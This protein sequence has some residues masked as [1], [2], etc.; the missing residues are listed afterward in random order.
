VGVEGTKGYADEAG[1]LAPQ[2]EGMTFEQVHAGVLHL[3]PPAPNNVLDIGAGTGRDAAA[4]ASRGFFVTA[5]EPVREL[6]ER[7]G[8]AIDTDRVRWIDDSLP[9]LERLRSLSPPPYALILVSAVWMHLDD[10]ERRIAM[11]VVAG[12]LARRGIFILTVRHGPIPEG[13]HLFAVPDSETIA[14]GKSTG[15]SLVYHNPLPDLLGRREMSW[16]AFAFRAPD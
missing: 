10:R 14:L 3:L 1:I 7:A 5:V 15:L 4:L 8:R 9:E 12:L 11:P 13:Q 2:M 16:S 6:R